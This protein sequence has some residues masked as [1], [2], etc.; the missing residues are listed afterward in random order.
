VERGAQTDREH[1]LAYKGWGSQRQGPVGWGGVG[2]GGVGWGGVGWG[3]ARYVH[4]GGCTRT[5][6]LKHSRENAAI[7][8]GLYSMTGM[9][10]ESSSPSTSSPM[11]FRPAR[12]KLPF[13]RMAANLRL[14][15]LRTVQHKACP[16]DDTDAHGRHNTYNTPVRYAAA[17]GCGEASPCQRMPAARGHRVRVRERRA[18]WQAVRQCNTP[19]S[20]PSSPVMTRKAART[21]LHTAGVM[22][23][24][25]MVP[26]TFRRM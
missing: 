25:Q 21:C 20:V 14:P 23:F 15:A 11:A 7:L 26:S 4:V 3:A 13:S 18:E 8:V 17:Q 16:A 22:E 9:M 5:P 2:W 10:G 12:K 1:A 19:M 6:R 24:A